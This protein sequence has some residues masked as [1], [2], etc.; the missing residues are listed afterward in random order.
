MVVALVVVLVRGG[1]VCTYVRMY[2][3]VC[4]YCNCVHVCMYVCMYVGRY[5]RMHACMHVCTSEDALTAVPSGWPPC[6]SS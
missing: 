4:V 1:D 3:C 5:V 2:M 6:P